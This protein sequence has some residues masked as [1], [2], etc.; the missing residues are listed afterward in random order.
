MC[1][2]LLALVFYFQ[3]KDLIDCKCEYCVKVLL[4]LGYLYCSGIIGV[5][6]VQ[7]WLKILCPLNSL[8]S[9]LYYLNLLVKSS[10]ITLI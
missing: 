1:H 6:M 10:Q 3:C 8:V 4:A 9:K 2:I 5:V 7:F